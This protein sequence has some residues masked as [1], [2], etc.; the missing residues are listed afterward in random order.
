[1]STEFD[2]GFL[3]R[4]SKSEIMKRCKS[5]KVST[6]GTKMDMIERLITNHLKGT[7]KYI[8]IRARPKRL[9]P[10]DCVEYLIHGFI[11]KSK[12]SKR[13]S[14]DTQIF[15]MSLIILIKEF[16]GQYFDPHLR[17]NICK[18]QF[19]DDIEKYGLYIN[20]AKHYKSG[21]KKA[22]KIIYGC[23][24]GYKIGIHIWRIKVYQSSNWDDFI[25]I[26]NK[27]Y[28]CDK[29]LV[30]QI[31]GN[32][33]MGENSYAICSN[34]QVKDNLVRLIGKRINDYGYRWRTIQEKEEKT[35]RRFFKGDIITVELNLDK[36]SLRFSINDKFIGS[37]KI[38]K[39]NAYYPI[40]VSSSNN[41]QFELIE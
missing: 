20:R 18:Y 37:K 14:N 3:I 6:N 33:K 38:A 30:E 35:R 24:N 1:M 15:P 17:F 26:T 27:L 13:R 28:I 5:C 9:S 40:I 22:R 39:A 8:K 10:Q 32:K 25:G 19:M 36:L 34:G 2:E 12:I 11:K 41:T 16:C 21:T 29:R 23:S 31:Q 4:L 7:A